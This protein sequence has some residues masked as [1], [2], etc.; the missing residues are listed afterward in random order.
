MGEVRLS[1]SITHH[2]PLKKHFSFPE[3]TS[4]IT[5][6]EEKTWYVLDKHGLCDVNGP[7]DKSVM[8]EEQKS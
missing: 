3:A 5:Q 2:Y 8:S 7:T 6:W 4:I 1:Y